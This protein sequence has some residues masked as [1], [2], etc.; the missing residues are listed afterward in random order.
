MRRD[1][2]RVFMKSEQVIRLGWRARLRLLWS[3]R[4][5]VEHLFGCQRKPGRV[6]SL[7]MKALVLGREA[8][9][10]TPEPVTQAAAEEG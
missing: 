1:K 9:K 4:I 6:Q 8:R 2:P 3:G 5:H 10:V 7:P